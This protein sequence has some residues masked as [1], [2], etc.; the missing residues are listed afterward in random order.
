FRSAAPVTVVSWLPHVS[1]R[2]AL[3]HATFSRMP[4]WFG[5]TV[6]TTA[7]DWPTW[8]SAVPKGLMVHVTTPLLRGTLHDPPPAVPLTTVTPGRS[9][10]FTSTGFV[11][12][13]LP[14]LRTL[15]VYVNCSPCRTGSLLSVL[16][17]HRK[18][19]SRPGP[20]QATRVGSWAEL[21]PGVA[22]PPNFVTVA[23]L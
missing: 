9:V 15:T 2:S 20:G 16:V 7:R 13:S 23:A 10:S 12:A 4:T 18:M 5:I 3:M 6:T 14:T 1:R 17:T 21:F 22:S 8:M 19:S 11:P